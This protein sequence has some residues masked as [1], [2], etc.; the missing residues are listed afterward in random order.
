MNGIITTVYTKKISEEYRSGK[1]QAAN[2]LELE[3]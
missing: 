2:N 3:M 1:I